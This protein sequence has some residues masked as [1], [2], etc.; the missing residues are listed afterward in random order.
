MISTVVGTAKCHP[1][2]SP[3]S[4]TEKWKQENVDGGGWKKNRPERLIKTM[5]LHY[6]D[7]R[8]GRGWN[9]CG[10]PMPEIPR[11]RRTKP[12]NPIM[13]RDTVY[14]RDRQISPLLIK[15]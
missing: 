10:E 15:R 2:E 5:R 6:N 11:A 1:I 8:L 4:E 13:Q 7:Q 3:T 9:K 14:R 12:E